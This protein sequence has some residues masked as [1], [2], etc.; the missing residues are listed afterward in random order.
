MFAKLTT[1]LFLDLHDVQRAG[2]LVDTTALWD[3]LGGHPTIWFQSIFSPS[4][5]TQ[6]YKIRSHMT[7]QLILRPSGGLLWPQKS[8]G[9]L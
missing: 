5:P 1:S 7:S 9:V 6:I 3:F 8:S 4:K 2:V